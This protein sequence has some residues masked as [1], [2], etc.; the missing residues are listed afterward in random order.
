[1]AQLVLNFVANPGAAL[2]EM[3]RVTRAG[4]T[5]AAAVWDFRGGLVYQRMFWDTAAGIDPAAARA[6]DRLF[7]SAARIARRPAKTV[8]Q[9]RTEMRQDRIRHHSHGLYEFR[10]LLAAALRRA[11]AG[12]VYVAQL[13]PDLRARIAEAMLQAYCSGAPDGPRSLTASAWVTWGLVR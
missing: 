2:G 10:R 1:V 4:G 7:A 5:V 13:S 12:W 6:R 3:C 8:C 9:C 11:R